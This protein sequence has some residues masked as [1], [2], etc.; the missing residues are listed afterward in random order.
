MIIEIY[1]NNGIEM[2]FDKVRE[3]GEKTARRV[4]TIMGEDFKARTDKKGRKIRRKEK[5]K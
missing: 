2:K 3:W 1:V 5:D 4:K